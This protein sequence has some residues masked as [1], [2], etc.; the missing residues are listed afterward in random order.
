MKNDYLPKEKFL[1]RQVI[2][3]KLK[4]GKKEVTTWLR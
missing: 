3:K 4:N 1:K 2:L